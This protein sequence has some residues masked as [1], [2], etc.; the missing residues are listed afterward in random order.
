[1]NR[2]RFLA[3]AA[4]GRA[5]G[6]ADTRA[7]QVLLNGVIYYRPEG[8]GFA[9]CEALAL[10]GDRVLGYGTNAEMLALA[11]AS[12]RRVD[13]GG[14]AAL[15]GFIDSHTH[16]A[17]SG[18]RHLKEVD[19]DLRSIAAI[20]QAVRDRAGR[21]PAGELIRGFKYDDTKTA[22]GRKLHKSDLD[23]A[24]P[25][26]P[27]LIVHRGGHTAF[28]NSRLLEMSDI[29][30]KTPDP[31]GGM[32]VRDGA[33]RLTGELRETATR[34][35][36]ARGPVY[37]RDDRREGV[38]L[39]TRLFAQAGITSAHDAGGGPDDLRAY[40]DAHERG[41][42]SCRLYTLIRYGSLD[43]MIAAGVRTGLGDEWVRVGAVK[44]TSDGSIS[45]RTARLVE[46]YTGR[47]GDRGIQVTSEAELY[48]QARKAHLAG[49]QIGT[50]ANGDEGIDIALR[51][52]ERLQREHPRR[53]P[54]FR[55]E[56]CT[57]INDALLDRIK[58]LDA[59][60][61]P[62]W[63]YVYYHGEKMAEYGEARL[64]RMFA[65]RSFLDRGIRVAPGSDY[66]PGPFEP[67][68]ALQSCVTRTDVGGK[69][70]G[71]KQRITVAD[72]VRASTING[73]WASH[74]E[75]L[76]GTLEPGKL[77]DLVVLSRDPFRAEPSRLA[78]I[79]VERTMAGG[80]WVWES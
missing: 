25:A 19:A 58:A 38:K 23:A 44:L 77:A 36:R 20:Q 76:K 72:A 2:R 56:H 3:S 4:L 79:K 60:P 64:D 73:A 13:L 80:R 6:A 67:M 61:T 27:V 57:V 30:E 47:P 35:L 51:V 66:V 22:D 17:S 14:R 28:A 42:L 18:V 74:E 52:Y 49:W 55:L 70:W 9:R 16:V 63:T 75:N 45:E 50:H 10:A 8:A 53:D 59:I 33:G 7:S 62:F 69:V 71:P 11:T 43:A 12:T 15:P 41:E 46:P 24:A 21:T 31:P 26:H 37:T 39:I 40:Q 29:H 68:M 34:A 48:E 54:R 1:M 5:L 65:M 32:I 78:E